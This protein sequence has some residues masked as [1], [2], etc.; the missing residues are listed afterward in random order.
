MGF[1]SSTS[2]L[3]MTENLKFNSDEALKLGF[4]LI[5]HGNVH[6]CP[7]NSKTHDFEENSLIEKSID[8]VLDMH[9]TD[10]DEGKVKRDDFMK[11][12]IRI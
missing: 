10:D 2:D 3:V 5:S 9:C 12:T 4:D 11:K 1:A 8:E 7:G 6:K